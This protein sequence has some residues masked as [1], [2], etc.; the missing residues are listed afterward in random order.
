MTMSGTQQPEN[1]YPATVEL[2]GGLQLGGSLS[3]D[4]GGELLLSSARLLRGASSGGS[5]SLR[6]GAPAQQNHQ[7][8]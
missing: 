3:A 4:A 1:A 2:E 6:A 7:C 5:V 8:E